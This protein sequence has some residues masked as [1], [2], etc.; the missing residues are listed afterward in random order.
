MFIFSTAAAAVALKF[1]FYANKNQKKEEI[2]K[3]GSE[4]GAM[5]MSIE[6]FYL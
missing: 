1:D 5:E 3:E 4:I 6:R 2:E